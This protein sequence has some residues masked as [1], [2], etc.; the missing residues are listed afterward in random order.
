MLYTTLNLLPM[1]TCQAKNIVPKY[2]KINIKGTGRAVQETRQTIKLKINNEIK[3]LYTKKHKIN[4]QLYVL[5]LKNVETWQNLW[6]IIEAKTTFQ[7]NKEVSLH[8]NKLANKINLIIKQ[9]KKEEENKGNKHVFYPRVHNMTNIEL[10]EKE[11]ELLRK[12]GKYNMGITIKENITQLVCETEN[13]IGQLESNQQEAIGYL[14]IK[15]IKQI[16]TKQN[17]I[18]KEYKHN[19]NTAKQIKQKLKQEEATTAEA[20]KGRTM[21]IIYKKDLEGKINTFIE[22][23]N[24]MELKADPTQKFQRVMHNTIKQ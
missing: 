16:L 3:C 6:P 23:N 24:I 17:V 5:H 8:H 7:F 12:G 9:T 10:S 1:S 19:I 18:N 2:A 20:D 15:N 4:E 22:D 13:A 14:A 11:E 21:V